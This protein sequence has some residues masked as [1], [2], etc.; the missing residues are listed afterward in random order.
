MVPTLLQNTMPPRDQ[1][2]IQIWC[3]SA[4]AELKLSN[5]K[6]IKGIGHVVVEIL[7]LEVVSPIQLPISKAKVEK[8]VLQLTHYLY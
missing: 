1:F 7:N 4:S 3:Q 6:R 2:F 5:K 8:I